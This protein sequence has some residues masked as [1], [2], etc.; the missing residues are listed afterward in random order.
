MLILIAR[1]YGWYISIDMESSLD[2]PTSVIQL[3][4]RF[5]KDTKAFLYPY[6]CSHHSK[7]I[8][9]QSTQREWENPNQSLSFHFLNPDMVHHLLKIVSWPSPK[10]RK[11][12]KSNGKQWEKD[13]LIFK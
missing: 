12:T 1:E 2:L 13:N 3:K 9:L 4:P 7:F 10:R 8:E 5:S 6:T 11:E